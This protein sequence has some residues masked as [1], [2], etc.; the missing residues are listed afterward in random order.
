MKYLQLRNIPLRQLRSARYG[1][2]GKTIP[3]DACGFNEFLAMAKTVQYIDEDG[4]SLQ[5]LPISNLE[6][7][8]PK[9]KLM[10]EDI[11][12]LDRYG[13]EVLELEYSALIDLKKVHD[14]LIKAAQ[15]ED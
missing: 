3:W 1:G 7:L 8:E 14:D 11:E 12:G 15:S 5:H 2:N 13:Y 9:L 10:A 6:L 4:N